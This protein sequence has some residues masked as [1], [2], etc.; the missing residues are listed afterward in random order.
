[1]AT[2]AGVSA[3]RRTF[4]DPAGAR[5]AMSYQAKVEWYNYLGSL[6]D[7]S[8][9]DDYAEWQTYKANFRLY[10]YIRS[11]YNPCRRL[12]EFYV[13]QIYP[14]SLLAPGQKPPADFRNAIP[15]GEDTDPRLAEAIAQF[16][17]WSNWQTGKDV[18]VRKGASL[19]DVLVEIDDVP[20]RGKIGTKIIWPGHVVDLD[21]DSQ[22][23][24]QGYALQYDANDDDGKAYLFKKTVDAKRIAYFKD[25]KPFDYGKGDAGPNVYGFVPSVWVKHINVGGDH[26]APAIHSTGKLDTLNE[27]ASLLHSYIRKVTSAP[28]VVVGGNS[29]TEVTGQTKQGPTRGAPDPVGAS[30]GDEQFMILKGPDNASVMTIPLDI[31]QA[32]GEIDRLIAE[33]EKDYPELTMWEKLASMSALTGPAA[34]RLLGNVEGLVSSAQ[35][36]YDLQSRK[37][38]AMAVA[39]GGWRANNGDW[40]TSLTKQQQRFLPFDLQSYERGD[41]DFNILPRPLVPSIEGE[42]LQT[43]TQ[44]ITA[45]VN[46]GASLYA[47][48]KQAGLSDAEAELLNQGDMPSGITQ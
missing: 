5:N 14:G 47:A 44:A 12:V 25:D 36:Q 23:N 46:A 9:Y 24:V 48:A 29:M 2:V 13:G 16:W 6:Y 19:G 17:Q 28:I 7:N 35:S 43:Q 3:F 30:Y 18:L 34:R 26:G 20:S 33:I 41:L 8:I 42:N 10:R 39:I 11:V 45:L 27:A 37:L 32:Y 38:F 1:M 31:E 4:A 40:G 22:D 15:L 21:L